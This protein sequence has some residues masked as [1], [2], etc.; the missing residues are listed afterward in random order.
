MSMQD[1]AR[2][3]LALNFKYD[4]VTANYARDAK[5]DCAVKHYVM[6]TGNKMQPPCTVAHVCCQRTY[7]FVM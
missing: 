6:R 3:E 1:E 2:V 4:F 7:P 5:L